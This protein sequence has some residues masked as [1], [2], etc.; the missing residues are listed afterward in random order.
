MPISLYVSEDDAICTAAWAEDLAGKLFTLQNHYV[1]EEKNHYY[2]T[3]G[4]GPYFIELLH[5]EIGAEFLDTPNKI[6]VDAGAQ[7]GF[8]VFTMAATVIFAAITSIF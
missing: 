1:L 7:A 2:F 8:N 5:N 6:K 4:N 3:F